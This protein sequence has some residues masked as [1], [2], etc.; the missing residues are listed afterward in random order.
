MKI[1]LAQIRK[2]LVSAR[3][4]FWGWVICI[5]LERLFFF[6]RHLPS[7]PPNLDQRSGGIFV[8]SM[9]GIM[10]GVMGVYLLQGFLFTLLVVR[11]IHDDPLTEPNAF[12]RT[13]PVPRPAL[14]AAKALLICC[15]LA[16]EH[17]TGLA[18]PIHSSGNMSASGFTATVLGTGI[19]AV[20]QS[21]QLVAGLAAFA[22]VTS[23]L[24]ELILSA[25][26][27][28]FAAFVS[29]GLLLN[30]I[31]R[32]IWFPRH[33]F[34]IG[35]EHFSLFGHPATW[36]ISLLYTAGFVL[37]IVWQYLTLRT[38]VARGLLFT[39]FL[40]AALWQGK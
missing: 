35:T 9:I 5:G 11:V 29:G 38:N 13:R 28:L 16:V 6:A 37:V 3:T 14:L 39:T 21:L 31:R 22:V 33:F 30:L 7:I 1:I 25:L 18:S 20:L 32:T 24:T 40:V 8:V 4:L 36:E 26:V 27:I 2:D 17:L 23:N 15:L 12:W 19:A 10:T 34:F